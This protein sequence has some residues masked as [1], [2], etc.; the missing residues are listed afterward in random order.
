MARLPLRHT[1]ARKTE[2]VPSLPKPGSTMSTS[3]SDHS[4]RELTAKEREAFAGL[5]L[6]PGDW[7][8]L[9][10]LPLFQAAWKDEELTME[11]EE[12]L[13][14]QLETVVTELAGPEGGPVPERVYRFLNELLY[15]GQARLAEQE[16]LGKGLSLLCWHLARDH[17]WQGRT[18]LLKRLAQLGRELLTGQEDLVEDVLEELGRRIDAYLGQTT[19]EFPTL[20]EPS[21]EEDEA[22]ELH[23]RLARPDWHPLLVVPLA[24]L[25]AEC[26]PAREWERCAAGIELQ[27]RAEGADPLRLRWDFL[28]EPWRQLGAELAQAQGPASPGAD[29]LKERKADLVQALAGLTYD[30]RKSLLLGLEELARQAEVSQWL[31]LR[32][33]KVF[34]AEK[35][36]A[37]FDRLRQQIDDLRRAGREAVP[38]R[39]VPLEQALREAGSISVAE[40]RELLER[41][42]LFENFCAEN[43]SVAVVPPE[44]V[45]RNLWFIGDLHCDLLALANA[46]DYIRSQPGEGKPHLLFLGDFVD[47]GVQAHETLLYLFRLIRDN[48][49][50]VAV[51]PGNH[52]EAYRWDEPTG[53]F[54]SS[55]EPAESTEALNALL[56]RDDAASRDRLEMGR[57]ACRFFA[58]RPRAVILPDGLLAAHGGFPHT[59][60]LEKLNERADLSRNRLCLQDFVWLRLGDGPRKRPYRGERGSEFGYQDFSRFCQRAGE[61]LGLPARRL[62]R[63]H[64]HVL[65]P[66]R[67]EA[68]PDWP[69]PILT[70]N[71]MCRRLPDEALVTPVTRACVARHVPGQLPEVHPLPIDE[72]IVRAVYFPDEPATGGAAAAGG[73]AVSE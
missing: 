43:E 17:D 65:R 34:P 49:G 11:E 23:A 39:A 60:L 29:V 25:L 6:E 69:C 55:V 52:D 47:R 63:G 9:S 53:R 59:D 2:T 15:H 37:C 8:A 57:L 68:H 35:V 67:Y 58:R 71:T 1:T 45:P 16:R 24:Q 4:V 18:R 32:G 3:A 30:E 27:L 12:E 56:G 41:P 62:V 21:P 66:E 36:E 48:P 54:V 10:P 70:I 44:A 42:L 50:Q 19:F 33:E 5:G 46:W 61:K 51:L 73:G 38:F 7:A 13:R 40:V 14:R 31:G 26:R 64:D 20:E 22:A 28:V 72:V